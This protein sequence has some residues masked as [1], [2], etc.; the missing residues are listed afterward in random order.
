MGNELAEHN[1]WKFADSLNWD[2]L[3][4]NKNKGVQALVKDLNELYKTH[5]ALYQYD[6]DPR[7]FE[8]IDGGDAENSCISFMRK[9]DDETL[10]V[11]CNFTP[12]PRHGY[13]L[14]VNEKGVYK[15][16][17]NSDDLKYAG[18]GVGS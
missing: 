15:Q 12:V 13:R 2:L 7:G 6:H 5:S 16:I 14:G 1:E 9:S 11:A 18:S 17:F 8:W 4:N 3:F 10:I